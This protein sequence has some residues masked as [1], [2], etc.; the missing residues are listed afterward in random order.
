MGNAINLNYFLAMGLA[1]P[2]LFPYPHPGLEHAGAADRGGLPV[3][4]GP[5]GRRGGAAVAAPATGAA[6]PGGTLFAAPDQGDYRQITQP[7]LR[8]HLPVIRP[9]NRQPLSLAQSRH[10]HLPEPVPGLGDHSP[11][12]LPDEKPHPGQ[13]RQRHHLVRRRPGYRACAHPGPRPAR[14]HRPEPSAACT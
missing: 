7:H 1:G 9:W 5:P 14:Q 3:S 10:P 2:E 4:P 6:P 13:V 8:R 12:D 11:A